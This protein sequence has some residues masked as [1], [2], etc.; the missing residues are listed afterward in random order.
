[1]EDFTTTAY[2]TATQFDP[3]TK[4]KTNAGVEDVV[5]AKLLPARARKVTGRAAKTRLRSIP[6]VP[7]DTVATQ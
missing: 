2:A 7:E 6:K 3:D 1:M 5:T 4:K